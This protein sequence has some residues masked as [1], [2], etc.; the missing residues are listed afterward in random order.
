MTGAHPQ[1]NRLKNVRNFHEWTDCGALIRDRNPEQPVYLYSESTLRKQVH[2]FSADFPGLVTYAVKANPH[3]AIINTLLD[4][5]IGAFDVASIEEI[6]QIRAQAPDATLH[7]NNPVKSAVAIA[8]AWEKYAVRS[9]AIDDSK[10]LNKIRAIAGKDPFTEISVRFCLPDNSAAYD[11]SS[12]FGAETEYAIQLLSM[13]AESG[14]KP[15]LTFHPG[16]QCEDPFQYARYIQA[17]ATIAHNAGL[18]LFRLNT[19]GGFPARYLNSRA[20]ALGVYF[21]A[22]Q[23]SF[24]HFFAGTNTQLLC[25]PGRSLVA[26]SCSLLTRVIHRRNNKTLFLNDGVY[27]GLGE[28]LIV[29]LKLPAAVWRDGQRLRGQETEFTLFGPTCDSKDTILEIQLPV[30]TKV[31]DFIE[32]GLLGAY[33]S[34][35]AT[36]FNGFR[37][38]NYIPVATLTDF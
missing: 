16:S 23:D 1:L 5:G 3:P 27:G 2:R 9:F 17:A 7:F 14:Y 12:K 30:D 22:V 33:G 15:S 31:D 20:P 26:Y 4:C 35:T 29:N 37:S 18:E 24:K 38:E 6:R 11:F 10:E 25:E 13:V 8:E 21:Q 32:F 19:G 28:Q 36:T 34:S